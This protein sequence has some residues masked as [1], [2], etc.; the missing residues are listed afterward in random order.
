M[1]LEEK[2]LSLILVSKRTNVE[3]VFFSLRSQNIRRLVSSVILLLE[4][5]KKRKKPE[6]FRSR[7][8]KSRKMCLQFQGQI[9][10]NVQ[11]G[12]IS[13]KDARYELLL[14]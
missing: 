8:G 12:E 11:R 3:L 14:E 13:P 6:E 5:M 2:K 7:V 1:R 9:I 4:C 10:Q